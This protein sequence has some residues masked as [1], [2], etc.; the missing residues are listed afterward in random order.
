MTPQVDVSWP[1][2]LLPLPSLDFSSAPRN[3]TI[4]SPAENVAIVRRSRFERS[5]AVL[6]VGWKFKGAQIQIFKDFFYSDLGNG[7]DQFKIELR[8]PKASELTFWA[9]R[10]VGGYQT[11]CEDGKWWETTAQLELLIPFPEPPPPVYVPGIP[12]I[13]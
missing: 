11:S 3:A 9:V 2:D 13:A 8:Y 7:I 12:V 6:T 4:V 5:Y 1:V 10:F